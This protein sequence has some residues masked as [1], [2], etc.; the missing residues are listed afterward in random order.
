MNFAVPFT[1]VKALYWRDR[2]LGHLQT[3]VKVLG[4]LLNRPIISRSIE[5][6]SFG[7]C[8]KQKNNLKDESS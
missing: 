1:T 4:A 5:I 2:Q 8:Y 6:V 3:K 7:F